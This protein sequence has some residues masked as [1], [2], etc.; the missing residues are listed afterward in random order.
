MFDWS[1]GSL[2]VFNRLLRLDWKY[3]IGLLELLDST[4]A[5]D[6][7]VREKY[8]KQG[9]EVL[10]KVLNNAMTDFPNTQFYG[11]SVDGDSDKAYENIFITNGAGYFSEFYNYVDNTKGTNCLPLDAHWN[12]LGNK[13]AGNT[14]S[15]LLL[16]VE[17]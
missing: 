11:F 17:R 9:L 12:H 10:E 2:F 4:I 15:K 14:L 13:V 3:Q 7:K 5:L 6:S 16:E 1:H 8:E